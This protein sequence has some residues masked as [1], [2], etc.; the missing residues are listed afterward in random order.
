MTAGIAEETSLMLVGAGVA[1][2]DDDDENVNTL[3]DE[4]CLSAVVMQ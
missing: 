1:K 4:S 3:R 2:K